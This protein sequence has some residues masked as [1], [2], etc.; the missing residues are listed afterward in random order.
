[1]WE[2]IKIALS[3]NGP[4]FASKYIIYIYIFASSM[5]SRSR[6][7]HVGQQ[8]LLWR[9]VCHLPRQIISRWACNMQ[10]TSRKH[11]PADCCWLRFF[12]Q[13]FL[14]QPVQMH[15]DFCPLLRRT[16]AELSRKTPYP[17]APAI[18]RGAWEEKQTL[19]GCCIW[20]RSWDFRKQC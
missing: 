1:M 10:L 2:L 17:Q 14:R 3:R 4:F 13:G 8:C 12:Y 18:S 11:F 19:L 20:S 7:A 9:F 5:F 16:V 15:F 6:G